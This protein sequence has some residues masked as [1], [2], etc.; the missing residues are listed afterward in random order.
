[1]NS[2]NASEYEAQAFLIVEPFIRKLC[3]DRWKNLEMDDCLSEAYLFFVS[4][5]R[6]LPNDSGHFLKDFLLVFVPHMNEV[7][8]KTPSSIFGASASLDAPMSTQ[9]GDST[10]TL[11]DIEQGEGIDYSRLEV[12]SFLKALTEQDRSLVLDLMSG[13]EKSGTAKKHGLTA[14]E[15]NKRLV[16][17]GEV[18]RRCEWKEERS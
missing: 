5:L 15:L 3:R 4:A 13:F 16:Q 8:R 7:N 2:V 9:K 11:L 18:Y 12:G 17:I 1:M 6:S 14:Y 10:W